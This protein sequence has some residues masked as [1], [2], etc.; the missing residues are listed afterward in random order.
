MVVDDVD[1]VVVSVVV[2]DVDVVIVVVLVVVDIS[3]V[4]VIVLVDF[5]DLLSGLV[6]FL[7]E[8]LL[9]LS[10]SLASEM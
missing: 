6:C 9:N 8:V 5:G 3:V 1:V 10:F 7:I 4:I 2:V